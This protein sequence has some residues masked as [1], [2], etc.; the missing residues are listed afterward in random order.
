L[1]FAVLP[2]YTLLCIPFV[3]LFNFLDINMK[4]NKGKCILVRAFK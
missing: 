2:I 1:F 4:H 3:I